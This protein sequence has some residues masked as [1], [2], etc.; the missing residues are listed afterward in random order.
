[1]FPLEKSDVVKRITKANQLSLNCSSEQQITVYASLFFKRF[2]DLKE[3]NLNNIK[4][5]V[6]SMNIITEALSSNLYG[7][8]ESLTIS[9]C[10]IDSLSAI[11]I[12][13]S[14][15]KSK[16]VTLCLSDNHITNEAK[17]ATSKFL[18]G[19]TTVQTINFANNYLK[20]EIVFSIKAAILS[21][22]NLQNIDVSNN[23]ITDDAVKALIALSYHV[24]SLK[25]DVE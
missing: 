11:A 4:F 1:M 2:T 21:C 17:E 22:N 3:L 13:L 15:N 12:L 18:H 7:T 25:V 9:N 20:T 5:D 16:I 19:N 6:K 14:L 10:H 23:E 24:K 8:L